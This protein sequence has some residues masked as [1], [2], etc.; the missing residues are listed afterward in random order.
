MQTGIIAHTTPKGTPSSTA[1]AY[2]QRTR[3][4]LMPILP[5]SVPMAMT[6]SSGC[7]SRA[8]ISS[9]GGR[10][11][12]LPTSVAMDSHTIK[13]ST[14]TRRGAAQ[15]MIRPG[16]VDLQ[17]MSGLR[18]RLIPCRRKR[19]GGYKEIRLFSGI[20]RTNR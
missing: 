8:P 9:S 7:A 1:A 10:I 19:N 16:I 2:P 18:Q 15:K 17:A 12:L 13:K 4:R 5:A 14:G 11:R 20:K 3:T 6:L